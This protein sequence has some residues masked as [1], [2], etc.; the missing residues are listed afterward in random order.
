MPQL[1][2]QTS[3]LDDTKEDIRTKIAAS[4]KKE[5]AAITASELEKQDNPV[6]SLTGRAAFAA[7]VNEKRKAEADVVKV[8]LFKARYAKW[9]R[10]GE[11]A[12]ELLDEF[13]FVE[14]REEVV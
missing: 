8:D 12:D 13:G 7:L 9:Q 2:S 3:K 11:I 4:L 14:P 6:Q 1:E 10:D 5:Y